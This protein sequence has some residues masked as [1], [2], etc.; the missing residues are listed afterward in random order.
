[1]KRTYLLPLFTTIHKK[2]IVSFCAAGLILSSSLECMKRHIITI[3]SD[4]EED[5]DIEIT[6]QYAKRPCL[7]KEEKITID[8]S[9]DEDK[10]QN[11]SPGD[12]HFLATNTYY[13]QYRG[14]ILFQNIGT[15]CGHI[16][17]YTTSQTNNI[18]KDVS[19]GNLNVNNVKQLLPSRNVTPDG[20]DQFIEKYVL[21]EDNDKNSK[22]SNL[23]N[24]PLTAFNIMDTLKCVNQDNTDNSLLTTS[25][26]LALDEKDPSQDYIIHQDRTFKKDINT[27]LQG[28]LNSYGYLNIILKPRIW[29]WISVVV[30]KDAL[31]NPFFIISDSMTKE[32]S[33]QCTK[34]QASLI[35]LKNLLT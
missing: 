31:N 25:A 30:L 29:H 15:V 4:S 1:M 17:T 26:I 16:S 21:Q 2:F 22:N 20:L 5:N 14:E 3:D 23:N 13:A 8:L 33:L 34:T 7:K 10:T 24:A 19:K 35:Y 11:I 27:I 9:E 32:H 18:L 6:G 28:I 12:Q